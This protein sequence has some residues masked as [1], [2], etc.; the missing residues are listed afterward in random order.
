M[1]RGRYSNERP[2][3]QIRL[4]NFLSFGPET[5][6]LELENLNILIGP[7]AAGKSNLIEALALMRSTP[8]SPAAS[9]TDLRGVVRRGGG[10]KEWIWKDGKSAVLDLVVS[11]PRGNQPL[12]HVLSFSSE[13]QGLRLEDERIEDET[14]LPAPGSGPYFYY[15]FQRGRPVV[16]IVRER[17]ASWDAFADFSIGSNPAGSWAYGYS[18]KL[19]GEFRLHTSKQFDV[20]PGVDSWFSPEIRYLGV[21]HNR[22]GATVAGNPPTY[23]APHDMLLM[24]PGEGGVYDVVRWTCQQEGQYNVQGLFS[25][26]DTQTHVA[27]IDVH[28]LANSTPLPAHFDTL[29]GIGTQAP[30]VLRNIPLKEGDTLDFI[31]G[32]GPKRSHG[33][34]STG[35]KATI[36]QLGSYAREQN[37][38]P[39]TMDTELSILAQRRDPEQY[40]E[41]TRL[42]EVYEKIRIYREWTFGRNTLLREP[43]R[44][45]VRNDRLEE[46][47]SNL[48]VFLSRL[49]KTPRAKAAIVDGLKDLYEGVTDFELI[50]EGGTVQV[51]FSE[52]N[53]SV[54]ATRLSDG[55]LRYLFLLAILCD[56][57]PPPLICIEEPELGLH[58]DILPKL[59]D[60]LVEASQRTQLVVTTHSDVLV[61][62]MSERPESVVVC[63]KHE[64]RTEMR[65]LKR[66]ALASW[67]EKYRLGELW[68]KGQIGGTRW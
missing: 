6:P 29:H 38:A 68:I 12:R 27:D 23:T 39:E 41:I 37:L 60:L 63:E 10:A 49:Q 17:E 14:G 15:R 30:F 52:G 7:N 11:N 33:S 58:P 28:I 42:S 31:V 16:Q 67:L 53:F 51:F 59:A 64:G 2:L 45:D 24:H 35:L 50:V 5:A 9:N 8:V 43:Q 4:E 55:T 56:P 3:L 19:G 22:T 40:P 62:A 26:L 32:I 54:P 36:T 25:G 21:L 66:E 20:L 48:G 46:D 65:R 57:D 1:K 13:D 61:D 47:F 44:A 34:G 18:H